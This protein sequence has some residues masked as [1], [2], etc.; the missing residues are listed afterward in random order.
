MKGRAPKRS[1]TG[2]QIVVHRKGQPKVARDCAE[3]LQRMMPTVAVI[4]KTESA[5][6]AARARKPRSAKRDGRRRAARGS[7]RAAARSVPGE[8]APVRPPATEPCGRPRVGAGR[9]GG[10]PA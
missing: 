1:A 4:A 3:S 10:D 9:G 8:D 6:A 7:E 2:S 5:N